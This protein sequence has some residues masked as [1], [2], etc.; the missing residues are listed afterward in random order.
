MPALVPARERPAR[1]AIIGASASRAH[2]PPQLLVVI[3]MSRRGKHGAPTSARS[4][5][6]E[7]RGGR[8]ERGYA[9][10]GAS[11]TEERGLEQMR[12]GREREVVCRGIRRNRR[13]ARPRGGTTPDR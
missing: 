12:P 3:T 10:G 11:G 5:A 8:Y 6:A 9:M 13:P 2:R 4:A 7:P 1:P